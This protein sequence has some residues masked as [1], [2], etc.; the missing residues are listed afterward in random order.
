[1]HQGHSVILSDLLLVPVALQVLSAMYRGLPFVQTVLRDHITIRPVEL[2]AFYVKQ[3]HLM[4]KRDRPNARHVQRDHSVL[5]LEPLHVPYVQ[6]VVFQV[7]QV[8]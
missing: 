7:S 5:H 8:R 4:V 6:Q 3:V 2:A 1:M